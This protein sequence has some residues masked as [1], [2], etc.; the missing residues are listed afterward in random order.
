MVM[1]L[2]PALGS[3]PQRWDAQRIRDVIL[4][5]T[6]R[7]S[8]TYVKTMTMALKEDICGS[9]ARR[10]CVGRTRTMIPSPNQ[11]G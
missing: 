9:S 5:E 8:L 2:L 6:K 1:R 11:C 10:V 3:R 7:V 4:A